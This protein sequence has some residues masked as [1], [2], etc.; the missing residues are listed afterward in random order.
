MASDRVEA[1]VVSERY[2]IVWDN[3]FA[4]PDIFRIEGET[5]K[6]FMVSRRSYDGKWGRPT[7]AIKPADPIILSDWAEVER[8]IAAAKE[9]QKTI[10]EAQAAHSKHMRGLLEDRRR[11]LAGEHP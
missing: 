8:R 9:V 11:A 2:L 6:T 5:A 1:V 3:R 10:S 4:G 7:R